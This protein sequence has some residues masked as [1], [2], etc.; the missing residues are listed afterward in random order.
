MSNLRCRLLQGLGCDWSPRNPYQPASDLPTA[1]PHRLR[2][3]TS[4]KLSSQLPRLAIRTSSS[5]PSFPTTQFRVVHPSPTSR[6][7]VEP[8]SPNLRSPEV[9]SS[10]LTKVAAWLI[11]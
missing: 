8:L 3:G 11:T 2:S 4:I 1:I 5:D 6:F 9:R 7:R 10:R